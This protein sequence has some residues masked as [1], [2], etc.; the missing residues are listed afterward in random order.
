VDQANNFHDTFATTGGW[1]RD[2]DV[3]EGVEPAELSTAYKNEQSPS[4]KRRTKE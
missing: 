2:V 4:S 1:E 3:I